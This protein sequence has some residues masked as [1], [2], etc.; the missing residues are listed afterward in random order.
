VITIGFQIL[1]RKQKT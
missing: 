1:Q